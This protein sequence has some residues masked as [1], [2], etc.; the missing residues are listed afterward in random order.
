MY[1]ILSEK[2]VYRHFFDVSAGFIKGIDDFGMETKW[3]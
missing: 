2:P 3:P 1:R